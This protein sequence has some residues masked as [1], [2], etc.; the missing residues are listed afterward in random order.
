MF[1]VFWG[2]CKHPICELRIHAKKFLRVDVVTCNRLLIVNPRSIADP[3]G[4]RVKVWKQT[5]KTETPILVWA[6]TELVKGE[7]YHRRGNLPSPYRPLST[8]IDLENGKS[9]RGLRHHGESYGTA[10]PIRNLLSTKSW[11]EGFSALRSGPLRPRIIRPEPMERFHV[12][13]WQ[14]SPFHRDFSG[15]VFLHAIVLKASSCR[16]TSVS[17]DH[18]GAHL[19]SR[20]GSFLS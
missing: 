19:A 3:S 1:D 9:L 2:P 16:S 20:D 8:P 17:L 13:R 15:H 12:V 6:D 18:V 10:L 5:G 11:A 14:A 7:R 4:E